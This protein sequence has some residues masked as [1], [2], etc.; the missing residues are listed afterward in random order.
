MPAVAA[1]QNQGKLQ[2][3]HKLGLA[4]VIFIICTETFLN[5]INWWLLSIVCNDSSCHL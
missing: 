4:V 2:A 3:L 5:E 1:S